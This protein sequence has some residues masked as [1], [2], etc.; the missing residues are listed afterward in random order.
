MLTN[1]TNITGSQ[2]RHMVTAWR[3]STLTW[4]RNGYREFCNLGHFSVFW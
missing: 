1:L 2:Y 3:S 4:H